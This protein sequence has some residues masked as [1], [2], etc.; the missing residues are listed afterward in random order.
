MTKYSVAD[1]VSFLKV[2]TGLPADK[3]EL[4]LCRG[5]SDNS[6][7]LC[8]PVLRDKKTA[9][10]ENSLY[11][12]IMVEYPNKFMRNDHLGNLTIMQHY[13]TPTRLLDFTLNPLLA[14][15]IASEERP[16]KDGQVVV[17]QVRKSEILHHTSDKALM[18][19]C[20]PCLDQEDQNGIKAYCQGH[21]GRIR[22]ENELK[23]HGAMW[24][25]LHEIRRECPAFECE[26]VGEHLL[27][28]YFVQPYKNN[29]RIAIQS[30]LFALF[31]LADNDKAKHMLDEYVAA[32]IDIKA[33]GKREILEQLRKMNIMSSTIYPDFERRAMDL[34]HKKAK[35]T[36]YLDD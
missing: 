16:D 1:I 3:D 6:F 14:L 20:L 8:P 35:W 32:T 31:G 10:D 5:H 27:N 33:N 21:R 11:R 13:G 17:C 36:G 23:K 28:V 9:E 2:F 15:Y 18:L 7:F 29:E 22:D 19:S 4:L 24:R 26:I 30:G 12:Q 25:F 34:V